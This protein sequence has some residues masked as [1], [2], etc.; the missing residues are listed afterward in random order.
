MIELNK[1]RLTFR[2]PDV[3]N[4]A[5]CHIEFKRTLRI[6]DDDQ[7]YPLPPG[8]DNFPMEHIE[9]HAAN[10]S[11]DALKRGGVMLPMYQSEALWIR[12]IGSGHALPYP[13]ALK[14]AAGKINAVSGEL[15]SEEL[16]ANP[17]D[18]VVIPD[19]PWLDGYSISEEY[20]R[21]FVAMPLGEGYTAEEQITGEAQ[22]GG[23]QVIA[24]PLKAKIYKEMLEEFKQQRQQM[25][26][27]SRSAELPD[28]TSCVAE[29]SCSMGFAPG[30]LMTQTI[31]EDPYGADA[32]DTEASSRCFVH[33][34]NSEQW[35]AITGT[36][37]PT[38]PRKA[39]DYEAAGLP[40][41]EHYSDAKVLGGSS[42]LAGLDSLAAKALKKGKGLLSGGESFS[43]KVVKSIGSKSQGVSEGD[44]K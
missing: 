40:W 28:D 30:G 43:P 44:W 2:F 33:V 39:K 42:V 36:V 23:L 25:M 17:Q 32:W 12:F 35:Q 38:A 10:L 41:F 6:P 3:H 11:K 22:F 31:H 21:Q 16:V 4:N 7:A 34:F 26:F 5:V 27:F 8:F 9:D 37:P 24:Y 18:Y 15:W 13:F 14:V 29:S 19:Q 20:I 1:S